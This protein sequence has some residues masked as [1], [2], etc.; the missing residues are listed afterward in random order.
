MKALSLWA[1]ILAVSAGGTAIL[2]HGANSF[3]GG[4]TAPDSVTAAYRDGAYLGNLSA[5]RGEAPHVSVG[6]WAEE[7]DRKLFAIAYERAYG[8]QMSQRHSGS[9]DTDNIVASQDGNAAFR[10]GL[11]VGKLDA[12][13]SSTM[14]LAVGRWSTANDRTAFMQGYSQSFDPARSTNLVLSSRSPLTR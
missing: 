11:Y 9:R 5:R 4:A 7:S 14:H 6:R 1:L 8:L 13:H 12:A 3:A 10:D 2:K